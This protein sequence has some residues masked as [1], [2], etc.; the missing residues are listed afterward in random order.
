MSIETKRTSGDVARSLRPLQVLPGFVEDPVGLQL[1]AFREL[2]Q[3]RA[4]AGTESAPDR[5]VPNREVPDI[6]G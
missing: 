1:A 4:L 2:D 6:A 3:I 5:K